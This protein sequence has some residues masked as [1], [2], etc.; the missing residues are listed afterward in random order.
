MSETTKKEK[1][2]SE[3]SDTE[4]DTGSDTETQPNRTLGANCRECILA[5]ETCTFHK[6]LFKCIKCWR[7]SNLSHYKKKET[8]HGV[9]YKCEK[10]G[11]SLTFESK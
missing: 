7:V 5:E 1:T 3:K 6:E 10:C 11:K 9:V 8:D 4:S 2:Q